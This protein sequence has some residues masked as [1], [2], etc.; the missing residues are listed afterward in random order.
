[1]IGDFVGPAARAMP[2]VKTGPNLGVAL[3]DILPAEE[4]VCAVAFDTRDGLVSCALLF[5]DLAVRAG[6]EGALLELER[7]SGL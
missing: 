4:A 1:M 7:A 6:A 3:A 2:S 5:R